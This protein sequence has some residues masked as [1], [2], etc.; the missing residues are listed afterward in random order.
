MTDKKAERL[1]NLTLAL[2]ATKRYLKKSEIFNTV[3]GYS[4]NPESMDRMFERDKNELRSLGIEISVGD[5]DPL[6]DDEP[7]YRIFKDNYGFQLKGLEPADVALLSVAA[8]L[9]NDSVLGIDAQAGLLKLESLGLTEPF[10]DA[11]TFNYRYENPT[12]NLVKI[13]SAI[14]DENIIKFKYKESNTERN[15]E[16]NKIYLWHGFWYLLGFDLDKEEIRNYKISRIKGEIEITKKKFKRREDFNIRDFLP[17][18]SNISVEIDIPENR[19]AVLRN[20]GTHISSED[21][22]DRFSIIFPDSESA[23]KEI[24]RHGID[25]KV[26]SPKEIVDGLKIHLKEIANV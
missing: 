18:T 23:L 20:Q 22:F 9:W 11:L 26:I 6:F 24:L 8:K 1:I 25:V 4:G 5:L 2:L 15:V 12:S 17:E 21:G 19:G 16:P 3:E 7:G 13:E 10:D 14:F